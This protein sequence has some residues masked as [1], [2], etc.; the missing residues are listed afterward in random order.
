MSEE[1]TSNVIRAATTPVGSNATEW[2][3]GR[4]RCPV[5]NVVRWV[6]AH[7]DAEIRCMYCDGPTRKASGDEAP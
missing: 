3:N 6:I 4:V 5:C 1:H 2:V 7:P